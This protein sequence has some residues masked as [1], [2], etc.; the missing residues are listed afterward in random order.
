MQV[1][2]YL[3]HHALENVWCNPMEDELSTVQLARLTETN[4]SRG[5]INIF[6]D[7]F[8]LPTEKDD[9]HVYMLG[10]NHP[11]QFTLIPTYSEWVNMKMWCA[12]NQLICYFYTLNGVI[13]PLTDIWVLREEDDNLIFAVRVN[14]RIDDLNVMDLYV[15]FYHNEYWT[16][17]TDKKPID[18]ILISGGRTGRVNYVETLTHV[19]R[20]KTAKNRRMYIFHNG[21][22]NFSPS[23][24]LDREDTVELWF[25]GSIA[26]DYWFRLD[27]LPTFQSQLDDLQKYLIHPPKPSETDTFKTNVLYHDDVDFF[28]VKVEEMKSSADGG[29]LESTINDS[30]YYYRHQQSDV[31][32]VTHR[33]YA[34][35]VKRIHEL[36]RLRDENMDLSKWYLRVM[37]RDNGSRRYLI[38]EK[39]HIK[40]LYRLPEKF[41]VSAMVGTS[42]T[43]K[44]WR[45]ENLEAST[46]TYLMRAWQHELTREKI[47]DAYG[48]VNTARTLANPCIGITSDPTRPY[49]IMPIGL[50]SESTVFEYDNTGT[51][52]G[53]YPHQGNLKYFPTN[54][55]TVYIEAFAGKGSDKPYYFINPS[56]TM[57]LHPES[58]YRAYLATIKNDVVQ[59][60]WKDVTDDIGKWERNDTLGHCRYN[61][62]YESMIVIGD[63]HWLVYDTTL[64]A[65]DGVYDFG[66]FKLDSMLPLPIPYGKIDLWL[67]GRAMV[68]GIDYLINYPTLTILT[69]ELFVNGTDQKLTIRGMGFCD[70]SL[71]RMVPRD[72][73][74]V[75]HGKI[76]VD[77]H[78]DL[79]DEAV[80]RI[81]LGGGIVNPK[82]L[83]FSLDKGEATVAVPDGRP[84]SVEDHYI[85]LKGFIGNNVYQAFEDDKA[86]FKQMSEYLS[87]RLAV[88]VP[89]EKVIVAN[90]Y[91]VYSPT[92]SN[93]LYTIL[94]NKVDVT[95]VDTKNNNQVDK[96]MTPFKKWLEMD[97]AYKGWDHDFVIIE[98]FPSNNVVEITYREFAF[99][100]TINKRYLNSAVDLTPWFNIVQSRG[101]G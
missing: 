98:P 79:H 8:K 25:D 3:I 50:I 44:H 57:E 48:Y 18:Q 30:I 80:S 6:H 22:L 33:D 78:Y 12:Q 92:L 83:T 11:A 69:K 97:L 101:R 42:A 14:E 40:E 73:G 94:S 90:R 32:M 84:F 4:G 13:F 28:L 7:E 47:L 49:F 93:I 45:A 34:L 71:R 5:E 99:L 29:V 52:L 20:L 91:R 37:V 61:R 31:R 15:R 70:A 63:G 38:N 87:K 62:Q 88:T 55:S 76:S 59:N 26:K 86:K 1:I 43:V 41:L 24:T 81:S 2:D 100:E 58:N 46:Y 85:P 67:N 75:A 60:D 77:S 35:P 65:L 66:V 53:F 27:R 16:R 72:Y 96:F 82:N 21:K 36:V 17:V 56:E 54:E 10:G 19:Q 51:L 89:E 9:Y 74:F 23:L 64:K 39:N 68:E 95:K